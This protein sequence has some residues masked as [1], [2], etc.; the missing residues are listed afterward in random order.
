M[1]EGASI[2][3]AGACGFKTSGHDEAQMS[4]RATGS[5]WTY[6]EYA[7]LPDDGNRYEVIDGEVVVTPAPSTRHQHVVGRIYR[8]LAEHAEQYDLGTVLFDVDVLFVS[9]QFL[10]P[11]VVFVPKRL[12]AGLTDRGVEVP[13]GLIVEV[14][15][16]SSRSIDFVNKPV[17]YRDFGV[18]EYWVAD[19][20]EQSVWTWDLRT[21][22]AAVRHSDAVNWR[23]DP[24]EQAL[25]LSVP[26]LFREF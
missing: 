23:P 3:G 13:P 1:E 16:P 18:P 9:G 4:R 15:S 25:V 8:A 17:R 10:R 20:E 26:K 24:A 12:R 14:L 5:G 19:P 22:P 6:A 2:H 7:R 11:D 21:R